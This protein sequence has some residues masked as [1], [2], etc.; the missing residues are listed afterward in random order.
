MR[1]FWRPNPDPAVYVNLLKAT[2]LAIR[3]SDPKA[4]IVSGS[5]GSTDSS[6]GN[7]PL[8]FLQG[9]YDNGGQPFFNAVGLRPYSFSVLPTGHPHLTPWSQL[10]QTPVHVHR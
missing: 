7:P 3:T 2:T 5:L 9:L 1:G 4:T 10:H 8:Q 6:G